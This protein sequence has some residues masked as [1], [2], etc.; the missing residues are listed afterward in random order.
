[1]KP[2]R[3]RGFTVIE[4][5][6]ALA[7]LSL[8]AFAGVKAAEG[9]YFDAKLRELERNVSIVM[10][11]LNAYYESRC[12]QGNFPNSFTVND[13]VS[14]G[15]IDNSN[16]TINP[17]DQR[18]LNIA[19]P[20][21]SPPILQVHISQRSWTGSVSP[22]RLASSTGATGYGRSGV[23]WNQAPSLLTEDDNLYNMQLKHMYEPGACQ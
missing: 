20:S 2:I 6:A 14:L 11:G 4:M 7:V 1:M 8:V 19:M 18:P 15:F 21:R 13:L 9:Y 23:Y 10:S 17:L 16:H 5:V 22:Q 3:E 12:S